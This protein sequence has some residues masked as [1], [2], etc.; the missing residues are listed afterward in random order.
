MR[1]NQ[2]FN[3]H[4]IGRSGR[5]SDR[6]HRKTV[7]CRG[8]RP[9]CGSSVLSCTASANR[10]QRAPARGE[11]R[12]PSEASSPG[13]GRFETFIREAGSPPAVSATGTAAY[14]PPR[15]RLLPDDRGPAAYPS[16]RPTRS[17]FGPIRARSKSPLSGQA[18]FHAPK[19]G[20]G[21]GET[22]C[23]RKSPSR[24]RSRSLPDCRKTIKE[25][26]RDL[27]D[28]LFFIRQRLLCLCG[29][30][31]RKQ[32]N[33]EE[34]PEEHDARHPEQPLARRHAAAQ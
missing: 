33:E 10:M 15:R 8:F 26:V 5:V 20:R 3:Q 17:A 30:L 7:A 11:G 4:I 27:A 2:R 13:D 19:C 24:R 28:S 32:R 29:R 6:R 21:C 23:R 16:H 34:K 25:A 31:Q 22:D 1:K 9:L 18:V 12:Q 14:E